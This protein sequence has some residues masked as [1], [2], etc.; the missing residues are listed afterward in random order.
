MSISRAWTER[1][2]T[3]P[4]ATISHANVVFGSHER[5]IRLG[6]WHVR[7]YLDCGCAKTRVAT[8]ASG[9]S[10]ILCASEGF[11]PGASAAD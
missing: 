6:D 9:H 5:P 1:V 2:V 3:P 10:D 7:S 8:P 11:D 4:I